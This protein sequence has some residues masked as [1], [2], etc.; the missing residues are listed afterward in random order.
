MALYPVNCYDSERQIHLS[1][2]ADLIV[3]DENQV[4]V[5]IRFGGYPEQVVAM[6][7]AVT[8]GSRLRVEIGNQKLDI[9]NKEKLNYSR[10]IT[11]DGTYAESVVF[12]NDSE[13]Q[14][15]N[16][17]D[18]DSDGSKNKT[19]VPRNMYIYCHTTDENE[20]FAE[21]DKKL[22][23]PLIP[24]FSRYLIANLHRRKQLR[25]LT[26]YSE[27]VELTVYKLTVKEDESDVVG[28]LE[29]GLKS[30]KIQIPN[31]VNDSKIFDNINSFSDYLRQF[32]ALI[33]EKIKTS[34]TPLYDPASTTDGICKELSIVNHCVMKNA[35][36]E[37]FDAQLAAAE[38]L[39]RRLDKSKLA[40]L[41]AECG[42]GK[43]KIGAAALFAHQAKNKKSF[44][45]VICPSHVSDKWVR[46]N[47]VFPD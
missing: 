43:T 4:L 14:N 45:V 25:K 32:G 16:D 28:I 13:I 3:I 18:D 12:L 24:E 20:L 30:G 35:G 10:K 11:H 1:N 2:Y 34:F 27:N 44:N 47:G 17:A 6:T 42:S 9:L 41:V 39:K 8:F 36:Y 46:E 15:A 23:V 7:D 26:V 5:G 31:A 33:G 38:G 29:N 37:L 40:L 22:S 21:L 19:P